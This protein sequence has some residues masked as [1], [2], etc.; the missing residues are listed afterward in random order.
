LGELALTSGDG[1]FNIYLILMTCMCY[2]AVDMMTR[3][4]MLITIGAERVNAPCGRLM[5][6]PSDGQSR[7]SPTY[8]HETGH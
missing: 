2:N 5:H 1:D 4:L 7:K 8:A 6:I 3:K